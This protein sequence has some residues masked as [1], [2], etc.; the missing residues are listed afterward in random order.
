MCTSDM[1]VP[2]DAIL[3]FALFAGRPDQEKTVL[4]ERIGGVEE[5]SVLHLEKEYIHDNEPENHFCS[6]PGGGAY[7]QTALRRTPQSQFFYF[8]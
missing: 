5:A 8:S 4:L 7:S 2:F 6:S 1:A 3:F